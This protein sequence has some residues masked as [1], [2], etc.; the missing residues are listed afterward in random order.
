M[1]DEPFVP[2]V[3]IA[4]VSCATIAAF[5]IVCALFYR[6][7]SGKGSYIDAPIFNSALS[8]IS[9]HIA[10]R[11]LS[12]NKA[13]IL[14]GSKPCYNIYETK[15]NRYVSLG[16]IESKFWQSFCNAAKMQELL[17]KQFDSSI[18]KNMKRLFKTKT[19]KE[20]LALNKK[21]DFCC[22][23]VKKI[24]NVIN[25]ADLNKRGAIITLDGVK[26]AALPFAFSSF[27]RLKYSRPPKLGEHTKEILSGIGYGKKAVNGLIKRKVIF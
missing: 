4:D 21:Y 12:R 6:E 10:H 24:E 5:S 1:S 27:G 13:T 3:Q 14:S 25:D 19:M 20:W 8:L 11:S 16:A 7:R 2:G 22:E 26:Q 23:P 18:T 17:S 9:M 15:D